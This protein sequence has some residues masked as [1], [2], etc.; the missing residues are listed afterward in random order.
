MKRLLL[1]SVLGAAVAWGCAAQKSTQA[2]FDVLHRIPESAPQRLA[3]RPV[4]AADYARFVAWGADWFRDETFGDEKSVTDVMGILDGVVQVPC[5][6]PGA[7]PS[8]YREQPV[9]PLFVRALDDLDGVR[10][11]L[12][13]GNGQGTT[14]DLVIRFPKGA[15]LYG[16]IPVPETVHTGLDVEAGEAWPLGIVAKPAN[17]R[18]QSLAYLYRPSEL[19]AGPGPSERTRVGLTCALCHYSLDIDG[20]GRPDLKSARLGHPTPGSPYRPEHAWG[21]GNQDL[22]FG[23][24]L[25]LSANPLVA[26]TVLS[27]PIGSTDPSDALAFTRWVRDNYTRSPDAVLRQ[28]VGSMLMHP[29][30]SADDTPDVLHQVVQ[31]PSVYTYGTWPYNSDGVLV[32]AGD[33]NNIVWTGSLD[34]TGLVGLAADRA[35]AQSSLLL[36][37]PTSPYSALPAETYARLITRFS[38]AVRSNP[39][40]QQGLVDDILGTSDGVPG[41]LDPES[42]VVLEGPS[43]ALPKAIY[44]APVNAGRRRVASTQFGIDG[45]ARVG[46]LALFGT[47]VRTPP[48]IRNAVN[49]DAI[50]A[51]YHVDPDEFFNETVSVALDWQRPPPNLSP[52]L[53]GQWALVTAGYEVFKQAGCA[54]CHAGGYLMDNLINRMSATEAGE[55]GIA[56]STTAGWLIPGRDLGPAIGTDRHRTLGTRDEELFLA[57]GYDP[58]TGKATATGGT[59]KGFFG[60]QRVGYKTP[61]LRNLWATPPYLHDGSVGVGFAPGVEPHGV[62]LRARLRAALDDGAVIHGM[63]PWLDATERAQAASATEM[64]RRPDAAL[65]LQALLLASERGKIVASNRTPTLHVPAGLGLAPGGRPPPELVP[66]SSLG[67]SGVG[68]EYWI[69]DEPGGERITALIAFLLALD[70]AP[71]ELPGEPS[72][73]QP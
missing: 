6:E 34:F 47:R 19:G 64:W 14:S 7:A 1:P 68:H 18:D 30:G 45:P 40:L 58:R 48:A 23:W 5:A 16:T 55:Y 24:L 38:P 26:F 51:K 21:I 13:Y 39:A 71:C 20:D 44:D 65:S 17:A 54:S 37:E 72:H 66:M 32:N 2:A 22:H 70:D 57:P 35:S 28:V 50:V 41:M 53:A 27:G 52:L 9:F 33:R 12:F 8:C 3:D 67:A 73:C 56:P 42:V 25:A 69:D 46:T 63:G 10:G 62:T 60:D 36:W 31:I 59:L 29:R 49:L 43:N 15:R 61:T 11:N 4:D